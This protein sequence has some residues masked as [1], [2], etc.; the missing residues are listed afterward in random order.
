LAVDDYEAR[1]EG[2]KRSVGGLERGR[3]WTSLGLVA[4]LGFLGDEGDRAIF[5][6]LHRATDQLVGRASGHASAAASS[7]SAKS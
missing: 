2:V 4:Q 3:R 5:D 7:R 6:A 1:P